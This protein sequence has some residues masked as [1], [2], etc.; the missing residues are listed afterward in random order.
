L[1]II[2]AIPL[3]VFTRYFF[4]RRTAALEDA[5]TFFVLGS[6]A[7]LKARLLREGESLAR[8]IELLAH[9]LRGRVAR[10]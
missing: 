3:A 1:V 4:E 8:E 7:S 5:R 9:E 2:G 6:R 10:A